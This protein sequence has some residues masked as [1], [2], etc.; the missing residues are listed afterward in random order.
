MPEMKECDRK[1]IIKW[2]N[3]QEIEIKQLQENNLHPERLKKLIKSVEH[4]KANLKNNP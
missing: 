2:I 3:Q 4:A 1:E